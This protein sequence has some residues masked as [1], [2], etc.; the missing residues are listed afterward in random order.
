MQSDSEAVQIT[1][2]YNGKCSKCLISQNTSVW[3]QV[4]HFAVAG[5]L[6]GTFSR[7]VCACMEFHYFM[8]G[9][10]YC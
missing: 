8:N 3:H 4:T 10:S 9:E 1:V 6:A 2:F 7:E 5:N